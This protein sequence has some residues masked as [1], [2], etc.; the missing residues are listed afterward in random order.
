MQNIL[1]IENP[2]SDEELSKAAIHKAEMSLVELEA[3]FKAVRKL[4][5][6]NL[7]A[8]DGS[9]IANANKRSMGIYQS[10]LISLLQVSLETLNAIFAT[11]NEAL[12]ITPYILNRSALESIATAIWL[13]SF[14]TLE[15]R[16]FNALR[17][18]LDNYKDSKGHCKKLR[19]KQARSRR[20]MTS[21]RHCW[22]T[23]NVGSRHLKASK[24]RGCL[25]IL[26]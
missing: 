13:A 23:P 17:L 24:H 11:Q 5:L 1:Q 21:P 10:Q 15:K 16:A 4:G 12:G 20:Y 14:D 2:S 6:E 26:R 3:R 9:I 19:V 7:A 22:V 8:E 18:T 25:S